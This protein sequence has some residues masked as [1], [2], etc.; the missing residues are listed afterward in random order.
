MDL[1]TK[2][3]ETETPKDK[4]EQD[5]KPEDPDEGLDEEILELLGQDPK[6]KKGLD[7]KIHPSLI[8][9]WGFWLSEGVPKEDRDKLLTKFNVPEELLAE[10]IRPELNPEVKASLSDAAKKRDDYAFEVQKS[11]GASLAAMG[12]VLSMIMNEQE[13]E[14]DRLVVVERLSEAARLL[15]DVIHLQSK[16]RKAFILPGLD[17][18]IKSVLTD[19]K[20]DSTLFGK[21]L[22]TKIKEAKVIDKVGQELKATPSSSNSQSKLNLNSKGFPKKVSLILGIR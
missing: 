22:A 3:E 21:N 5:S 14:V 6:K 2:K 4:S 15:T 20:T 7:V 18:K 19:C 11:A 16:S 13:E 1:E 10:G 17:A 9:R 8:S 12:S